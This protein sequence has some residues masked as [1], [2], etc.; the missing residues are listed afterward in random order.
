MKYNWNNEKNELLKRTRYI[1]F[2]DVISYI[3]SD[4]MLEEIEHPNKEKYP[5]QR[6]FLVNINNFIYEIPYIKESSN[7]L[8]LK[9]I[10][11]SRKWTKQLLGGI[12]G[13]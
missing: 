5:N 1:S 9:T 2:E 4:F 10:I 3:E 8:F 12:Y 11:P 7:S 13:K 6:I